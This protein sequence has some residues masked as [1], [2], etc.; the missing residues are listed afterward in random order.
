M[1]VVILTDKISSSKLLF[2]RCSEEMVVLLNLMRRIQRRDMSWYK[3]FKLLRK[4][5]Q[6][7][8]YYSIAS[9][10]NRKSVRILADL[11]N[12]LFSVWYYSVT[13]DEAPNKAANVYRSSE[14]YD[15]TLWAMFLSKKS[16]SKFR[17]GYNKNLFPNQENSKNPPKGLY[18]YLSFSCIGQFLSR[19]MYVTYLVIL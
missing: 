5:M 19:Y 17:Q 4:R 10:V 6:Q 7:P 18:I 11:T 12:G 16:R 9:E 3:I 8:T 13:S 15:S 2:G 14:S 1:A